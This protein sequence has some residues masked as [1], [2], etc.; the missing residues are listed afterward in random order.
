MAR[1]DV[2]PLA[3]NV[4]RIPTAPASLINSF[5]LRDDD[6]G[7]T[8]I[9]AGLKRATGPILAALAALDA[10]PADV[11]RIVMTHSHS[12][13]AGGLP[14]LAAATGAGIHSHERESVY[15][16]DGR[17]PVGRGL[18]PRLVARIGSRLV[19]PVTVAEEFRDGDVMPVAG[20]LRVVHTP[21]HSPGHVSLLHEP[22]GVLITGDAVFNIRGLRWPLPWFCTDPALNRRSADR[23][24]DL[25]FEIA[26]FTHGVE[27]RHHARQAVRAFLRGRQR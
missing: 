9:D 20:G 18:G 12:D 27:I 10:K 11:R 6:G 1:R 2:V 22:S 4:W 7:I 16:R 17:M 26:A 25:D 23:L 8:L 19:R 21:G 14:A 15:L 3:S 13:H 5:A 24:G